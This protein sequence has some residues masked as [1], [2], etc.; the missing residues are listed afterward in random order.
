MNAAGTPS[1]LL[2]NAQ[3]EL[4][5]RRQLA[6]ITYRPPRPAADA[7]PTLDWLKKLTP[8]PADPPLPTIEKYSY[9]SPEQVQREAE[10]QGNK[11]QQANG[12]KQGF[13]FKNI[14]E[15]TARIAPTIAAACLNHDHQHNGSA[16]DAPYRLYKILQLLDGCGRGWLDNQTVTTAL[17]DK[18]S[19]SFIYG[20]RQ[21]K[22]ILRRGE[23]LF[24]QRVKSE[25]VVRIRLTSRT[26][27]VAALDCGPLRGR[28]VA[29]PAKL[30]LGCGRGRQAQ[31]NAA[32]YTAVH[33]GQIHS[34]K[35]AVRPITRRRVK[36]ISG[37]SRYR[38]RSYEKRMGITAVHNIHILGQYS[39]YRL[40]RVRIHD[41]L[42]AYKHTDFL[43]KINRHQP[44][45]HY[46]GVRMAN[47]YST[48]DQFAVIHSRRQATI[49]RHLGGLCLM[50][51]EGIDREQ[52]IRLYH[53]NAAAAVSAFNRDPRTTAYWPLTGTGGSHLWRKVG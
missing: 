29:I 24:W 27:L 51:S 17:T 26:K 42:P 12:K 21:L 53:E 3:K 41:H 49:N 20:K 31:V 16:L 15:E 1:Q 7:L 10:R 11:Q 23:G 44:G 48:P 46:I 2:L 39:D 40:E 38:Q 36:A 35:R 33:T 5:K 25:G 6:G 45:A 37:C 28:E 13:A 9:G 43:G 4:H 14:L 32:L 8:V 19:A 22:I 52:I 34:K 30:L 18:E 50:G 47:S